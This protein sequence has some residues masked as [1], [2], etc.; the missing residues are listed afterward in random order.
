MHVYTTAIET[1][2]VTWDKDLKVKFDQDVFKVV[3]VISTSQFQA[4]LLPIVWDTRKKRPL[5]FSF[6]SR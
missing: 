3:S 4:S 5:E 6:K 1:V 2:K